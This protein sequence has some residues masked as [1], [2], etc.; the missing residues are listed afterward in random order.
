[1]SRCG[2]CGQDRRQ[3][4]LT[5][6]EVEAATAGLIDTLVGAGAGPHAVDHSVVMTRQDY[7]HLQA[8]VVQVTS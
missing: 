6:T 5:A 3:P 8:E 7:L 2:R 1:M 4:T